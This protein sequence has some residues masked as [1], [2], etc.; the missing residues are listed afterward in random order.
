MLEYQDKVD[1]SN[2]HTFNNE[3]VIYEEPNSNP[4]FVNYYPIDQTEIKDYSQLIGDL[5]MHDYQQ[6]HSINTEVSQLEK[7]I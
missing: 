2:N 1:G 4:D 3:L 7:L 5:G 6:A